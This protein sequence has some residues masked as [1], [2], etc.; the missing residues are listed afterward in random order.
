MITNERLNERNMAIVSVLSR[1]PIRY[2]IYNRS[3]FTD[4]DTD[5]SESEALS[6]LQI[7]EKPKRSALSQSADESGN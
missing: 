6:S 2:P 3:S 7:S 5:L 4:T 1:E